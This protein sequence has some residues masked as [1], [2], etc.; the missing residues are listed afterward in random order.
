MVYE[1]TDAGNNQQIY[2]EVDSIKKLKWNDK[3]RDAY[4]QELIDHVIENGY[5]VIKNAFAEAEVDE[6]LQELDH[7]Y[8]TDEAGPASTGGRNTFEGFKTQRIYSLLNKSRV[9]DKFTIHPSVVALNDYF[10]DPGWL[11]SVF[12]SINIRPGENP[13]TLHHDD[14]YTTVPR[15]H[16]PFGSAIMVALD[17][18][19]E[20]NGSTVVIPKSH[21]WDDTRV[22]KRS[23]AIPVVMPRGS[24]VFFLGTLWHGG[25]HNQSDA[26]RQALT[27]Q[28]CQ[29][30]IRPIENQFL[31]VDW[32]KLQEIPKQIVDLMGYQVGSPFIGFVDGASPT[33][34]V[35]KHLRRY[36]VG[37]EKLSSKL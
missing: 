33:K 32:E 7:L 27:V 22:P 9:F 8:Q 17:P 36:G 25:G 24:I 15:P 6:A 14:G 20:T 3:T 16:R 12:Q 13:Q 28:Y 21:K 11:I 31:G 29:P 23:E 5:V 1:H 26:D 34:A 18:Y 2:R 30:W 19:T 4:T 35:E 10:M 37:K